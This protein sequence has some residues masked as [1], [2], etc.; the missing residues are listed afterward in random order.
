MRLWIFLV[1]VLWS[2]ACAD[3]T[4]RIT[5]ASPT[6]LGVPVVYLAAREERSRILQSLED[7]G[8]TVTH[9]PSAAR[10][11]LQVDVGLHRQKQAC[12]ELCNVRYALFFRGQKLLEIRGRGWTG[13]CDSNIFDEL[14][15]L[16]A[17]QF[18][19]P[20]PARIGP[21]AD[22]DTSYAAN[23]SSSGWAQDVLD[24]S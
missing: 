17:T 13:S 18:D 6:P 24:A 16:L 11:T 7:V 9:D 2:T 3:V 10:Y 19:I 8:V 4:P 23:K 12:G 15:R 22:M 1:F 21:P 14:S 5:R 20:V